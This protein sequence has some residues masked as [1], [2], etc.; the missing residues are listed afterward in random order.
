MINLGSDKTK[1]TY[2]GSIGYQFASDGL[3]IFGAGSSVETRKIRFWNN[4]EASFIG[5]VK[6]EGVITPA[7]GMSVPGTRSIELGGGLTKTPYAGH[8]GYNTFSGDGLDILGA[9]TTDATRRI[10][11]WNEGGMSMNGYVSIAAGHS[12]VGFPLYVG[13]PL[14]SYSIYATEY[15]ATK[16]TI[17]FSD[18]R[19]KDVIGVSDKSQDVENLR[20]IRVTDYTLKQGG[21]APKRF[22][23][24]VIAQEIREVLPNAVST[25]RNF[26]PIPPQDSVSVEQGEP[27]GA[28][29]VRFAAGH[30]FQKDESLNL[31][32]D[33]RSQQ[34][35]VLNVPDEKSF[36]FKAGLT[37]VPKQV[38]VV[39]RE[40]ND[41]QSVDYQQIYMTAVSALQEVDRRLQLVEQREAKVM[42]LERKAARVDT[43]ERDFAELRKLVAVL[44]A[45]AAKSAG[46]ASVTGSGSGAVVSSR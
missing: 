3:D 20:R 22:N 6:F 4:G 1:G 23:K 41:F 40:V 34:I 25:N 12:T 39:G 21:I 17:T 7:G 26:I 35:Q 42:E 8:I 29:I 28:V 5:P 33:G 13:G 19:V 10:R 14:N 43:L 18:L 16:G 24:G 30:G 37:S 46:S 27:L 45:G 15:I 2:N 38:R 11:I 31:E 9:G 44:Q 32:L 36:E